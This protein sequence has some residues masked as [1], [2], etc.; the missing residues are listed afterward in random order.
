LAY[1][2]KQEN[3]VQGHIQLKLHDR[4]K[5]YIAG[6]QSQ[7]INN[8]SFVLQEYNVSVAGIKVKLTD[9]RHM[10]TVD[11]NHGIGDKSPA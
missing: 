3:V 5:H 4:D 9:D 2:S 1:I 11:L 6:S 7:L 10:S 8:H